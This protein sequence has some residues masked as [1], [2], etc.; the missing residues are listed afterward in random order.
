M[1]KLTQILFVTMLVIT[2]SFVTSCKKDPVDVDPS[3]SI[4]FKG[5]S[6][7]TSADATI[8]TDASIL[9]GVNASSNASTNKDLKKF[10]IVIT[11][12]NVPSTLID[13]TIST[14]VFNADYNISFPGVGVYRIVA[15]VTDSDSQSSEVAF[16]IT[17]EQT[18][19]TVKKK[20]GIEMG[21]FNDSWGS[22]YSG[23]NELVYTV[24]NAKLNQ[25]AVDFL[26]FKG[27]TNQNTVAA[28]DDADA[29]TI[30]DF[31]LGD[32]TVK[33][34]TR[35]NTTSMTAAEFDAIGTTYEFPEF[36]ATTAASKLNNL[37]TDQIVYFKTQ[38]GKRGYIK[39]VDL[40]SRGDVA[41][42][43]VIFEQ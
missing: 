4:N 28:P 16:N 29:N 5:G 3:P 31:Q 12:N 1:R 24:A 10:T 42:F 25:S 37:V 35:F 26:F 2:A 22:F 41:K 19:V 7:Y 30:S 15:K 40:Y 8:G 14:E 6:N 38:A 34:Q 27:A 18:G 20:T 33:N 36:N 39:I 13:S 11:T 21:S 17:V 9:V 32:W 23:T 43:E